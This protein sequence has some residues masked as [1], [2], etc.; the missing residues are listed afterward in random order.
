[1]KIIKAIWKWYWRL[2]A[3]CTWVFVDG[4]VMDHIFKRNRHTGEMED[5]RT[6]LDAMY[7]A[8]DDS[9]RGWKKWCAA[10]KSCFR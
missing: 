7:V 4:I 8:W 6:T 5:V 10:I 9:I 3:L 1:M 2:N